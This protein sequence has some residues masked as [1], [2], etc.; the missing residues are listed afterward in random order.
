MSAPLTL[1][2]DVGGTG[3]KGAVLTAGGTVVG[4]R[5]RH[6]TPYPCTP[7]TLM[8]ALTA[9]AG[10]LRAFDRVSVGF[11][12]AIRRGRVL[13]VPA[14]SRVTHDGPASPDLAA[15][16]SGYELGHHLE[17]AFGVPVRVANDADV[18]GCAAVAG[19]GMELVLTLG[20]GLGTAVF[21]EGRLLPHL[22]LSHG[23]FR[24]SRSYDEVLGD[25]GRRRVGTKRWRRRV[26]EA[27]A[28]FDA[29]LL[30]DHCYLGGGNA[31]R[32]RAAD[33]GPRISLVPN[34][35]GILGGIALWDQDTSVAQDAVSHPSTTS[36]PG[37][38]GGATAAG[39]PQ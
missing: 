2:I 4:S 12:G 22:E 35:A 25:V 11:P 19:H 38:G 23:P 6:A 14:L 26:G 8:D 32:L 24:K 30:F 37:A 5:I 1:A 33:L 18:Q 27:I 21:F 28:A 15:Q 13:E 9:L 10:E 39:E 29:M 17:E 36:Q 16:W 34:V 20:T 3:L 7:P 31:K